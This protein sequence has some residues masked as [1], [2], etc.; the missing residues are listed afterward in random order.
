MAPRLL[1][2]EGQNKNKI[3]RAR[4][5]KEQHKPPEENYTMGQTRNGTEIRTAI[6]SQHLLYTKIIFPVCD[7]EQLCIRNSP[8][9]SPTSPTPLR[10]PF[11]D[12]KPLLNPAN[13]LQKHGAYKHILSA[14]NDEQLSHSSALSKPFQS[15]EFATPKEQSIPSKSKSKSSTKKTLTKKM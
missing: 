8:V 3:K 15:L 2:A 5:E 7:T 10:P 12:T 14:K 11:P 4:M 6:P 9:S 13:E 1:L